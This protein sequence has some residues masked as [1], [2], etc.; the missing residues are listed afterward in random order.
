M[1]PTLAGEGL[2]DAVDAF[3]ERIGFTRAQ[4]QRVFEAASKLNLRVKLHAEQLSDSDGAALAAQFNALSADH[5]EYLSEVGVKAM[6]ASGTAAVLLPGAYY[7]LR[8]KQMPPLDLLRANNVTMALATDCNP[9]TSP[10]TSLLLV[11]NMAA[12]LFAMTVDECLIG[13]TRAAA[14]ALGL[15]RSVGT[16]EAGKQCDLA[17]WDIERP[18]D[19]VYR[20]GFNPL[21]ARVWNGA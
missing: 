9:G 3:C 12:T 19:L 21:H 15:E 16:L 5:L 2:I 20:M 8:E 7:F 13:V 17:I 18:A 6:A 4:T 10:L 14:Q 1:L 11:M